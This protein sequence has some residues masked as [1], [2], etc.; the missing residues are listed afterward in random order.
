MSCA[1]FVMAFATCE[2]SMPN[3]FNHCTFGCKISS[4]L[5]VMICG[6]L[7]I[8]FSTCES[9]KPNSEKHRKKGLICFSTNLPSKRDFSMR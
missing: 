6:N 1:C 2:S 7:V 9:S 5:Q 4:K 3:S 8:V